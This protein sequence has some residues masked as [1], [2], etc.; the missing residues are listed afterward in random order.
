MSF[1][2][3][4]YT[5]L[6]EDIVRQIREKIANG[7]YKPGDRLPTEREI[8]ESLGVSKASV[9]EAF[10]VLEADGLIV[11]Q[12][13]GGRFLKAA[14]T[15][16]F[17]RMDGVIGS[18]ERSQ[19]LD[20]LEARETIECKIAELAAERA[21]PEHINSLKAT[22]DYMCSGNRPLEGE[23]ALFDLDSEFHKILAEASQNFVFL[24]W[25][26]LSLEILA[27]TRRK[28]LHLHG[29]CKAL[30][31]ELQKILDA[32][33][34]HDGQEASAAMRKHLHGVR[35]YIQKMPKTETF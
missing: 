9:R 4:K 32:V 8:V 19:I 3:V 33:E 24:N 25:L 28:T 1:T 18:L 16:S 35:E 10:R 27:E 22:L 21:T 29:R 12:Q 30:I 11:S 5:R 26:E 23:T 2:R 31:T 7:E 13:G 14:Q 17:F 34:R 6:Y 20:L 15:E